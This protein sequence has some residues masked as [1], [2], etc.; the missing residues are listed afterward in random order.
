MQKVLQW[1]KSISEYQNE[2][3]N[4]Q[5]DKPEK[6]KCGCTK[7]HKWGKYERYVVDE[8][9]DYLI[10]IKRICCVKCRATYSFLPSFCV[11]KL[12][13]SANFIMLFLKVLILKF[14]FELSEMKRQAYVFLKRF[15]EKENLWIVFL[16]TRMFGYIT[17]NQKERKIKI[18]TELLKIHKTKN[19]IL[20]FFSETG[21]H[22]MAKNEG[23]TTYLSQ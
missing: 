11:S 17:S 12:C 9:G 6:C 16:R 3:N 18:F 15:T 19:L 13:F 10:S 14:N 5:T 22:F 8:K 1:E 4:L 20:H 21:L 7:F 2:F 23:K